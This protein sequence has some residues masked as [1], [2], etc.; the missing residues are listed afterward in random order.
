MQ[1]NKHASRPLSSTRSTRS[2]FQHSALALAV[3]TVVPVQIAFAESMKELPLTQ[4]ESQQEDQYN[5]EKSS[6]PKYTQPLLDTAKTITVIPQSVLQDRGVTRLRD[7]L[8]NVPGISLAAGEGGIPTGDNMTIRG[9]TA[10]NDILIDGVRDIAGYSRDVYNIESVEVSKGPSSALCGRGS[11]GGSINLH[12]KTAKLDEFTDLSLRVG[13]ENDHRVQL[14]SNLTVRDSSALRINLL[15]DAGEV[16]GR[17]EVENAKDAI[18]L[19]FSTGL[20]SDSRFSINA[21]YQN[22]DNLPDYG[23]P[24]VSNGSSPV[25]ELADFVGS[26]PPVDFHNFYGNVQRD[27]EDIEAQSL[28]AKY[29]KD[30]SAST[31]VR[32]LGR[33]GS[34]ER[35]S[36]VTAPRFAELS[37]STAVRQSDEKT[38]DTLDSLSVLQVDMLGRYETNHIQHDL[39]I[40]AE[41]AKEKFERW[42]FTDVV[43]DNLDSTPVLVDLYRPDSNITFTGQYARTS[44]DQEATGD[45]IAFYAFDT[46]TLTSQ[47]ELSLGLRYDRFD[48]NYF[49]DLSGADPSAQLTAK[50]QELSWNLGVVY[51]PKNNGAIYFGA[52]NSFSPS[53]EDLTVSTRGNAANLEPEKTISYELGTKWTLFD[54][55]LF[56]HAALFRS[57]KTNARTDA[58][59]GLFDDDDGRFDTLDGR[60]RVDGLELSA[61]GQLTEQLSIIAAYTFQDSEVVEAGGDDQTDQVGNALARTP[62][63]SFSLWGRYAF[64]DQ[65]SLGL[66]T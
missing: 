51:K 24:W 15:S 5:V 45:T 59:D 41:L 47:W 2:S 1:R 64:S 28:T 57:E 19:S 50:D 22:Q 35:Q 21:E 66:G 37:T 17:D 23:L 56:T 11:T 16:A 63:H 55:R 52:G 6:A 53:A 29:E 38:R 32:V 36:V 30:L 62:E 39:V 25:A 4:V 61:T 20:G 54:N 14:D 31:R 48:T 33:I 44:K 7:A 40:G 46:L 34:V 12:S 10:R 9:F 58:P 49:Y 18:A 26:A 27:F 42:N 13:S 3:T 65:L 43:D 60:Q 8:R